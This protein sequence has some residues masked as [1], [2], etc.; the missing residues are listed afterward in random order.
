MLA[1][2]DPLR[3][4]EHRAPYL[5]AARTLELEFTPGS[6]SQYSNLGYQLAGLLVMSKGEGSYDEI[7]QRR[8]FAP[9]GLR[10]TAEPSRWTSAADR[11]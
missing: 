2:Q 8:L 5:E 11:P 9:L 4:D 1:L 10:D 6:E 7:L 3:R